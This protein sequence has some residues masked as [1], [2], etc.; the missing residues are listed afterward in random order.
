MDEIEEGDPAAAALRVQAVK[1]IPILESVPAIDTLVRALLRAGA[2]PVKMDADA[3]HIASAA[4]HGMDALITW[5]QKHIATDT[6]RR[7]VEAV[8]FEFGLKPPRLLTPEL[9]LLEWEDQDV[10]GH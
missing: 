9:H 7:L 4:V 2:V 3:A 5:N 8:L 6:K 10:H 1:G